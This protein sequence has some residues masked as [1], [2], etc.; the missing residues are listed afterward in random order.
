VFTFRDGKLIR[1]DNHHDTAL[2]ASALG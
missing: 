1:N 2:W